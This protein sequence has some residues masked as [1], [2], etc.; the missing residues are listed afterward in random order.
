MPAN[1]ATRTDNPYAPQ[2]SLA[3]RRSRLEAHIRAYS[4]M[5]GAIVASTASTGY[6]EVVTTKLPDLVVHDDYFS[7][8]EPGDLLFLNINQ[9]GVVDFVLNQAFAAY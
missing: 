8:R 1:Q 7:S 3:H 2:K 9:S 4:T 6:A 5:A